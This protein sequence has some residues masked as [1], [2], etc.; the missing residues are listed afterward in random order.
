VEEVA[1]PVVIRSSLFGGWTALVVT[2]AP[3][4]NPTAIAA[5]AVPMPKK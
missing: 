1:V 3:P 4:A 2:I 5:K